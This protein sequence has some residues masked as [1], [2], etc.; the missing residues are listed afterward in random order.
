MMRVLGKNKKKAI[1]ATKGTLWR[2]DRLALVIVMVYITVGSRPRVDI[3]NIS[4][5]TQ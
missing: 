1:I 5:Y 4:S 2:R 3:V